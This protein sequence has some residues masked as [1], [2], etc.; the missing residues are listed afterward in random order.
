MD[1]ETPNLEDD[2]LLGEVECSLGTIVSSAN[3]TAPLLFKSSQNAGQLIIRSEEIGNLKDEVELLFSGHDFKKSGI[4]SKPDPFIEIY[5][6]TGE[7]NQLIY[8]SSHIDDDCN[9]RWPKFFLPLRVLKTKDGLDLNLLIQCWNYNRSTSHKL[10]GE[11]RVTTREILESPQT[12]TLN[13]KV[14]L[15]EF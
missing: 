14:W 7:Q 10:I 2:D 3:F 15:F 6:E 12:F 1:N 9:P 4:F 5:K 8:R 11:V 13:D